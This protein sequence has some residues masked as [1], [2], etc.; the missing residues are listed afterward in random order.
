ML[1]GGAK[2]AIVKR[3]TRFPLFRFHVALLGGSRDSRPL[4]ITGILNRPMT[5]HIER[6]KG[7]RA[8]FD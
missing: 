3:G 8:L 6:E 5:E 2:R 1:V 4:T 7:T